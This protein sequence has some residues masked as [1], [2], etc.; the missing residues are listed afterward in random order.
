[1]NFVL[2]ELE[3]V[4]ERGFLASERTYSKQTVAGL[5]WSISISNCLQSFGKNWL[6]LLFTNP[7]RGEIYFS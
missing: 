3:S 4:R 7:I 6:D 2:L 5:R 1:M